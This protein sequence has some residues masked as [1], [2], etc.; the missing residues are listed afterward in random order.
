MAMSAFSKHRRSKG[1]PSESKSY[2]IAPAKIERQPRGMGLDQNLSVTLSISREQEKTALAAC[3]Q[4]SA[5]EVIR[6]SELTDKS[7]SDTSQTHV[8]LRHHKANSCIIHTL[9]NEHLQGNQL[10]ARGMYWSPSE[11]KEIELIIYWPWQRGF[12]V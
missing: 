5:A 8:Q 7:K 4:R 11:Y 9:A 2:K 6:E 3:W 12:R 1:E 10:G